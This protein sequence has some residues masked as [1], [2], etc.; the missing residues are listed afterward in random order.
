M[1]LTQSLVR[2]SFLLAAASL[3]IAPLEADITVTTGTT[4]IG[5]GGTAVTI[6]DII[7]VNGGN[8]EVSSNSTIGGLS[9][10][11]GQVTS[12]FQ[13]TSYSNALLTINV[14]DGNSYVYGGTIRP[15]NWDGNTV[16][17]LRLIKTGNGTQELSGVL[18]GYV[19]SSGTSTSIANR[20]QLTVN[21]G[22]LKMSGAWG[23]DTYVDY[24][25]AGAA[26]TVNTG[27]TLEVARNWE[28]GSGNA[29]NQL[30]HNASNMLVNGGT[31]RFTGVNQAS[32]ARSF[33]V[34]A[35]GATISVDSGIT[36]SH[37]ATISGST[38]GSV[39]LAGESTSSSLSQA[40]GGTG[41]WGAT[42]KLIKTGS[43][44]WNLNGGVASGLAGG[45]QVS[46]GTLT[47]NGNS[48]SAGQTVVDQD[49][50]LT[51]GVSLVAGNYAGSI[52][53][54]GR[55]NFNNTIT[56]NLNGVVQGGGVIAIGGTGR[57]VLNGDN[58]F[59]GSLQGTQGELL[60]GSVNAARLARLVVGTGGTQVK[61]SASAN[62][63]KIGS[64]SGDGTIA[65]VDVSAT[66]G[67]V[68]IA[69][70]GANRDDAFSGILSGIGALRK[71]GAYVQ[72]ISGTNTYSGGTV[73]TAGTLAL[74]G[75][76]T[77]GAGGVNI[78][79]G[80]LDLSASTAAFT[81]TINLGGGR[82]NGGSLD[83]SSIASATSGTVYTSLTG[84]AGLVK[85][86]S[87]T[88]T[89][90]AGS[91]HTF[92]G[93]TNVNAGRL[94]VDGSLDSAVNVASGATLGGHGRINGLVT[95]GSGAV[96]DPG[97][98]TGNLTLNNLALSGG[99][100]LNW[101][102]YNAEGVAGVGYDKITVGGQL[103][104]TAAS[105][106][107][108]IT[109]NLVSLANPTDNVAG[110]AGVFDQSRNYAFT[111]LTYGS[112]NM[113]SAGNI[114]DFFTIDKSNLRDA[115]G[116]LVAG[117][118]SLLDTGTGINLEYTASPVPEHSTYGLGC[119]FLAMAVVAVRRGR[120]QGRRESD[121]TRSAR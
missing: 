13:N 118:F 3:A 120:S 24:G 112:L 72:T 101:Q 110:N 34:G 5:S 67:A 44:N 55:I 37:T 8:L 22:V 10:T 91:T 66:P 61:F 70:G 73:I 30:S 48:A 33:T 38:G 12:G 15:N 35:A 23:F 29:F 85:S 107:S 105:S 50:T 95:L 103:D 86:G 96:L 43:G 78:E 81:Q 76:G 89:L 36:F 90:G 116:N 9:G 26:V 52:T 100:S 114:A 69:V 84:S 32:T 17:A 46:G 102:V 1:R 54:N 79:G 94:Q 88:L 93:S 83:V 115:A 121:A 62:P 108:R 53:N 39:T 2:T 80:T 92:T 11:G 21:G 51:V 77:L 7:T 28:Y 74:S 59:S 98:S 4:T 119:A 40:V 82:I 16:N 117:D 71:E 25:S 113:G 63:Y 64:L 99:S 20:P 14:A 41:T 6:A 68:T 42:S 97:G 45:I 87:G 47:L 31:L 60:M 49:G 111:F 104:L 109:L 27:G 57:L 18:T 65:L 58:D 75:S 106:S 19:T 56:Q